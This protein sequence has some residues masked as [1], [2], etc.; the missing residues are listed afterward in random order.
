MEY[1]RLNY[2]YRDAGNYKFRDSV[3]IR[4][5]LNMEFIEP[6]MIERV[7][8]IPSKV[9]LS[10]LVPVQRNADDHQLHE[11]ESIVPDNQHDS[12]ICASIL[13]DRFRRASERGWFHWLE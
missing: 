13:I 8:F 3:C 1:S 7:Y 5:R 11:I 4:G 2:L 9:G 10:S 12:P 6:Y